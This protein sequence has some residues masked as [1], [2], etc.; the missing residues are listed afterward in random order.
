[1]EVMD[2]GKSLKVRRT[3]SAAQSQSFG[4]D[5]LW[6]GWFWEMLFLFSWMQNKA[7]SRSATTKSL[8]VDDHEDMTTEESYSYREQVLKS[9]GFYVDVLAAC[10]QRIQPSLQGCKCRVQFVKVLKTMSQLVDILRFYTLEI[11]DI[12]DGGKTKTY[13]AVVLLEVHYEITL[14]SF[15]IK[16]YRR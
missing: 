6:N 13:Q 14:S 9:E 15:K 2:A 16:T 10:N 3:T 8:K 11:R 7:G 1:M 5:G 12:T 4:I